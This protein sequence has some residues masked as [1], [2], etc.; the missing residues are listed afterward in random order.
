MD[1]FNQ[2]LHSWQTFYFTMGGASAALIG[3]MFVALSLGT[4]LVAEANYEDARLFVTPSVLY[5]VSV[6]LI[7]CIMLVPTYSPLGLALLLFTGGLPGFL[8]TSHYAYRLIGIA[9]RNQDFI[10]SDWLAQ[11]IAPLSGYGLLLIV[12][13]AFAS[14]HTDLAFAGAWFVTILLLL[15]AI[16]NTWSLMAWIIER[17]TN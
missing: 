12:A 10:L 2:T 14:D 6:L 15:S 8:L 5:F 9:K 7:A 16:T 13:A 4:S 3:L 1:A 11:V 17:H